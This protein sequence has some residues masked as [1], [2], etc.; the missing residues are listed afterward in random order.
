MRALGE[1][2]R[3]ILMPS[4][5]DEGLHYW[6]CIA[7]AHLLCGAAVAEALAFLG[8]W[9]PRIALGLALVYLVLKEVPDVVFRRGRIA[10]GMVDAGFVGLGLVIAPQG[11]FAVSGAIAI[12]IGATARALLSRPKGSR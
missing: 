11:P 12:A 5:E 1:L 8:L 6:I 10:D 9:S 2:W 3:D 4:A 7:A